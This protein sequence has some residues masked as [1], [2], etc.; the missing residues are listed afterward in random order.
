MAMAFSYPGPTAVGQMLFARSS[1]V[2]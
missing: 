2:T 1:R